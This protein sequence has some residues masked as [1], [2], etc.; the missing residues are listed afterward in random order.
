MRNVS[1]TFRGPVSVA[2]LRETSLAVNH[3]DYL[4]IVGPSGS[5]KSTLLNILGLLDRPTEGSFEFDGL[6]VARLKEHQRAALRG[7]CIGFIFQSFHLLPH[8]TAIENVMLGM[9][10]D[11]TPRRRRSGDAEA[12]LIRVG[13]GPKLNSFPRTMSGGER[14]R[15]SIARALVRRPSLLLCDE[16][17]G[18]LDSESG[19]AVLALFEE[20]RSDGYTVIVITH[21]PI[22]AACGDRLLAIHDG[23]VTELSRGAPVRQ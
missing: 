4:T 1:R 6:D 14:Q 15:V 2:A 12:A 8:R 11:G 20:L 13:L 3:G 10:Y 16:P 7:K 22:V 19:A 5:G 9:L 18:N 17:T 21:D 23:V